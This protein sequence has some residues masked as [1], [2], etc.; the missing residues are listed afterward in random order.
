MSNAD[1]LPAAVLRRKAVVY[2]RQSTPDA[3]PDEPGE[4][5]P[6][7]RPGRGARRRWIR[8]VEVIDDDLGKVRQRHGRPTRLRTAGRMALCR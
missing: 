1:L 8:A 4:P 7:V 6:P 3:S 5:A 2:V